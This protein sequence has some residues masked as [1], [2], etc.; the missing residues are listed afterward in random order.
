M[1]QPHSNPEEFWNNL[2][3]NLQEFV[4]AEQDAP[5][6]SERDK[7]RDYIWKPPR[8]DRDGGRNC[9]PEDGGL[10]G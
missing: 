6:I 3:D 10:P 2:L 4:E 7:D 5:G 1:T 8:P 9:V